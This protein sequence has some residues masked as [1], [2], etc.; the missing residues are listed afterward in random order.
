VEEEVAVK[1]MEDGASQE[2][3]IRFL[4]EA[5]IMGQ[6]DHPNIIRLVGATLNM[7]DEKVHIMCNTPQHHILHTMLMSKLY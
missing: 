3:R 6:F 5:A 2:D 4:Q 7:E 1:T